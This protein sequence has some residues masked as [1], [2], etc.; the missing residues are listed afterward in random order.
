MSYH[1]SLGPLLYYWPRQH[2]LDFYAKVAD[3]PVDIVYVGETVCSRRHELRTDDWLA[4]AAMLRDAGKSVILSTRTLIETGAEAQALRRQCQQDDWPVEAGEL[5]AVRLLRGRPFVAGPHCNAYHGG[6]LAWL[7]GLGA[8]RAVMPLE[9]SQATL[10]ELMREKH[11]ALEIEAMVW[12][13]CR[14]RFPHAAS[15][16]GTS[17]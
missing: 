14:W 8:M 9:M 1:I 17:G 13:A 2:T 6:T 7:A 10:A 11:D 15:P 5:G 3:S 16:R 4:L 12:G